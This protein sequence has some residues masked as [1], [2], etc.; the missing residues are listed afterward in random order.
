[1]EVIRI[2]W[3]K[4]LICDSLPGY[5]FLSGKKYN[6]QKNF[7]RASC[8][9]ANFNWTKYTGNKDIALRANALKFNFFFWVSGILLATKSTN[10]IIDDL[11]KSWSTTARTWFSPTIT[12]LPRSVA[13][14]EYVCSPHL[15]LYLILFLCL[16]LCLLNILFLDSVFTQNFPRCCT[17]MSIN[18]IN[19]D[20]SHKKRKDSL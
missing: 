8:K 10:E 14:T 1:M 11:V 6:M 5:E 13:G 2:A 3:L 17:K 18:M 16:T 9:D 12:F 7:G 20:H 15:T 4:W 19:S